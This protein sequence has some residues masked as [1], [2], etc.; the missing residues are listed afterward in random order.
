MCKCTLNIQVGVSL[1]ATLLTLAKRLTALRTMFCFMVFIRRKTTITGRNAL[2]FH[3][4]MGP[5]SAVSNVSGNRCESDCI[6]RGREFDPGP[7]PYFRGD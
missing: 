5:R 6:S 3:L 2:T 4:C 1:A 7:V